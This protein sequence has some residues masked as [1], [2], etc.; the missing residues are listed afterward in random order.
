MEDLL[1]MMSKKEV[2]KVELENLKSEISTHQT[3]LKKLKNLHDGT[4]QEVTMEVN[5]GVTNKVTPEVTHGVNPGVT[6][7]MTITQGVTPG[8]THGV[9]LGVSQ[10]VTRALDYSTRRS[11]ESSR[12]Q[13]VPRRP[14]SVTTSST[15]SLASPAPP[16]LIHEA[17]ARSKTP[18]YLYYLQQQSQIINQRSQASQ[19]HQL[20]QIHQAQAAQAQAAQAQAIQVQAQNLVKSPGGVMP[21]PP[22][23]SLAQPGRQF[24]T[25]IQKFLSTEVPAPVRGGL[26]GASQRQQQP[27]KGMM[28]RPR[29]FCKENVGQA[30]PSQ[31]VTRCAVCLSPANFLCSGCQKVYYCTVKCQVNITLNRIKS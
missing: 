11:P 24:T 12:L 5:Q 7:G 6:N 14:A 29:D 8:V 18:D 21:P 10:A 20:Q 3:F 31:Q 22:S 23:Q 25:N 28:I 4:H 15:S 1:E 2:A 17:G 30:R 13:I 26:G 27:S 9:T 19:I 16:D